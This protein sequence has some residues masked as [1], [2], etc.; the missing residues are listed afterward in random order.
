MP[1]PPPMACPSP[2]C[3]Y[4]TAENLPTYDILTTHLQMHI[5]TNHAPVPAAG[6]Q[7]GPPPQ[8]AKVDKR[9]RPEATQDMSEHDFRFFQSE[10]NLYKRATGI[11]GQTMVDELWSCMS[12]DL[13]KLA[14]DQ[15]GVDSLNTEDLMMTRIKTLAVA[16]LHTA[17]HTV[18]LQEA[19]QISD[20]STKAFAARVRGI[21]SNCTLSKSC[22]CGVRVSYLEETVYHVVLAGLRDRELQEAC[23]TQALLGN[24]KDIASLVDFCT[25][26]E[27]GQMSASAT[28]GGLNSAY[29][30]GKF[31]QNRDPAP[32]LTNVSGNCR[33]C[34]SKKH[35]DGSR[36]AREKECKAFSV[37]CSKCSKKSHFP[38]Q[39][40][41]K[42]RV[43]AVVPDQ[44]TTNG[45]V[46]FGFYAIQAGTWDFPHATAL[47]CPR[48]Q[49]PLQTSNRF[50]PLTQKD[51]TSVAA[52][53][54]PAPQF[55]PPPHSGRATRTAPPQPGSSRRSVKWSRRG[56]KKTYLPPKPVPPHMIQA[57]SSDTLLAGIT[58]TVPLLSYGP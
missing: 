10:W 26:K 34:G 30:A 39:C 53:A 2:G 6:P 5:A 23:T 52:V 46:T 58:S 15:G 25:A 43:A 21:A 11:Q 19:Q 29:R 36:G 18:H 37:T 14:F 40:L 13:K 22:V 47:P 38:S 20:E 35:G 27:S 41:S 50:G 49:T 54:E 8:T 7:P 24:I 9:S 4:T 55:P 28:I 3:A 12:S 33:H 51:D 31:N 42:P 16:V 1:A 44:Q 48:S 32:T 56:R 45:A 57:L 17:I